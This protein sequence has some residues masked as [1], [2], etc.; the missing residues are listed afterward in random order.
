MW[1]RQEKESEPERDLKMLCRW[2]KDEGRGHEPR[3]ASVF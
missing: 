3:D 2:L 1:E